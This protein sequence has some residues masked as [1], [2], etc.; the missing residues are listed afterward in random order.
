MFLFLCYS[1]GTET[2]NKYNHSR[3][4]LENYT[5]FHTKMGKVHTRFQTRKAK[6]PYPMGR[7]IP[8]WLIGRTLSPGPVANNRLIVS[9]P[10]Q[11]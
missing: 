1:F 5:R 6:K 11:K 7:Y 4:S 2:I 8:I 9:N 3:S 10:L